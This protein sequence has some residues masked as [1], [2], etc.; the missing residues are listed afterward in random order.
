M[1]NYECAFRQSESGK[2]FEWIII[3]NKS[4]HGMSMRKVLLHGKSL[5]TCFLGHL[6]A[7][8]I[9]ISYF[10][11]ISSYCKSMNAKWVIY[12]V[13]S[14]YSYFEIWSI[15]HYLNICASVFPRNRRISRIVL[16]GNATSE[17]KQTR[18]RRKRENK[19]SNNHHNNNYYSNRGFGFFHVC[20]P[21]PQLPSN[22]HGVYPLA[23]TYSI[24]W[25]SMCCSLK[26]LA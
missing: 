1:V 20:I 7:S 19:I 5:V 17:L 15:E 4:N 23:M 26:V 11:Q 21:D 13:Y 3:R 8:I 6:N 16:R 24:A 25:T 12:R 22:L 9:G 10:K 2:Y 18:Q 14:I